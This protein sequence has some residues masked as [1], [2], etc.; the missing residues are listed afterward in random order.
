MSDGLGHAP[1]RGGLFQPKRKGITE[2]AKSMVSKY[3]E[4]SATS[5]L[6]Y[7]NRGHAPAPLISV[8]I[9]LAT[10]IIWACM[11]RLMLVPG[12]GYMYVRCTIKEVFSQ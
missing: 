2:L 4:Q 9:Q 3:S 6:D 1:G 12:I 8:N 10:L 11:Y 5:L 7:S